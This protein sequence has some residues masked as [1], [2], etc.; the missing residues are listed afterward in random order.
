M[1]LCEG[2]LYEASLLDADNQFL[3][4]G[5]ARLCISESRGL[6]WPSTGTNQDTIL[7][8]ASS[9]QMSGGKLLRM[10]NLYQCPDP[11]PLHDHFEYDEI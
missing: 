11:W 9:L 3:A 1:N 2:V 10:R 8:S 4:S 7:K 5:K 6:F